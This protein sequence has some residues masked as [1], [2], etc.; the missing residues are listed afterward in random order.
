M[1]LSLIMNIYHYSNKYFLIRLTINSIKPKLSYKI[2]EKM[3]LNT[4]IVF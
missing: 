4:F 2:F 1:L 3:Y